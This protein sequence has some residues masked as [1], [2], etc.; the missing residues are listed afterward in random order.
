MFFSPFRKRR[1]RKDKLDRRYGHLGIICF[2]LLTS[3]KGNEI[4]EDIEK[5]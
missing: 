3:G 4:M 1:A 5:L 2:F